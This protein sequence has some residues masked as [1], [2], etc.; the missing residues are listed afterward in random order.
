MAVGSRPVRS[1][2][3]N[4]SK[5]SAPIRLSRVS[6]GPGGAPGSRPWPPLSA[7]PW[8]NVQPPISTR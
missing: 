1:A 7:A 2:A 4:A 3:A 5:P 8:Q 6:A